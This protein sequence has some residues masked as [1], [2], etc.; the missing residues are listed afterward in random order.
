MM[1][2]KRNEKRERERESSKKRNEVTCA[3]SLTV[4][5]S[6]SDGMAW[7]GMASLRNSKVLCV[8]AVLF[9]EY[10]QPLLCRFSLLS[11]TYVM[12]QS[13]WLH[14]CIHWIFSIEF[15]FVR[16]IRTGVSV[17]GERRCAKNRFGLVRDVGGG[18]GGGR[19]RS[20][21]THRSKLLG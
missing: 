16:C 5:H 1:G 17:Q 20:I 18:E 15:N 2:K 9:T 10:G 14:I 7:H 3:S 19:S 21:N 6:A 12:V 11:K 4:Q 13:A 8:A